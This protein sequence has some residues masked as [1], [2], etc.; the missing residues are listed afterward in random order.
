MNHKFVF[1]T[2]GNIIKI[3][4]VLMALPLLVSL[5]YRDGNYIAFLI[6]IILAFAIGIF[7]T[8]KKSKTERIYAKEGLVIV[9]LS[10]LIISF[11]GALPFVISGEIPNIINALFETV[12]G[13]TTTGASII[14][15]VESVSRSLLFWR[16]LT[17]WIGGMG[18]LVFILAILPQTNSRSI[19]VMRAEVPGPQVD[20]ITTKVRYT[21][22]ILYGIYVGLT[23][24]QIILLAFKLPIYDSMINAFATAGTGGFSALSASIG[25]YNSL[26]VEIVIMIFMFLFGVN[27][28]L[29]YMILLGK[30]KSVFKNEELRWYF[31][32]VIIG[33]VLLTINTLPTYGSLFE[34]IRYTS[35][36]VVS[37]IT[38]TGFATHDFNTWPDFSKAILVV[39]MFI[40]AS[41]GSTGGGIKVSRI[42]LYFKKIFRGIRYAIQ[43]RK[44][45]TIRLDRKPVNEMILEGL[46]T[47]LIT[48]IAIFIIGILI[49]SMEGLDLVSSFSAVAATIN[50]VGPGLNIVG[51][52]GNYSSLTDLSK[53]TLM[54]MMLVGRLEIFPILI[55]F[56][57][58]T[59]KRK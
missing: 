34:T 54:F 55:L 16:N 50:N 9:G 22:R 13:F 32:I 37:I 49:I 7:L 40:G 14:T 30:I 25:G 46:S 27:F 4:A 31:G 18:I 20:K 23:I 15:D 26:Y 36:Q 29:F 19:Y 12:S 6:P 28:L 8:I 38:T 59:W 3:E 41:A 47:Y 57:P 10:W 24:M 39:L 48:Y 43:P 5:I 58:S 44:I 35:F 2:I 42:I 45:S 33:I 51:P 56:S 1:Y 21:A 11:F 52:A 17:H 53:I